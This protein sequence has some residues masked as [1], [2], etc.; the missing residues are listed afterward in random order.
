MVNCYLISHKKKIY[1]HTHTFI[2]HMFDEAERS[3]NFIFYTR[4]LSFERVFL[5]NTSVIRVFPRLLINFLF[6]TRNAV[7]SR[8]V[9]T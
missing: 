9:K 4:K 3:F 2:L 5:V 1:A 8:P 6:L 7:S